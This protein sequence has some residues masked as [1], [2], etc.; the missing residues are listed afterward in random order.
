MKRLFSLLFL[1]IITLSAILLGGCTK[2][3]GKEF[4]MLQPTYVGDTVT[5]TGYN[6]KKE[7]FKVFAHYTENVTEEVTD[8][9]FEVIGLKDALFTIRITWNGYEEDF[10]VPLKMDI[11]N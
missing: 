11:Y 3:N 2:D 10:Y 6:F 8:F 1:L 9:T 4:L 5:E 7:D